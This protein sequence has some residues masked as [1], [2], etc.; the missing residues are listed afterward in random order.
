MGRPSNTATRREE[1]V[2]GLLRV[3]AARGYGGATIA[4]IAREAGLPPG[5]VH[6][7]FES[8][9]EI[10]VAVLER[11]SG[12]L[13]E[14]YRRR[15]ARAGRSETRGRVFAWIDAHVALGADA[16]T[17]AMACWVAIGAEAL[18]DPEVRAEFEKVLAEDRR[19]LEALLR[20]ALTAERRSSRAAR[21]IATSLVAAVQGAFQLGCAAP[22]AIAPGSMAPLLR[23]MA[24]GLLDLEARRR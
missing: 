4:E 1:L 11:L 24:D 14:R 18:R 19:T 9:K 13:R 3:M 17:K 12:V 8:K 2:G 7:H 16:N 15:A 6:Y 5:I 20:E 21:A 10:L 23:R 22:G